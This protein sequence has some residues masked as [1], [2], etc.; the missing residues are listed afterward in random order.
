MDKEIFKNIPGYEGK[1][2]VSNLG[3][4]KSLARPMRGAYHNKEHIL[5]SCID[6]KG[7]ENIQLCNDGKV[8][9]HKIHRLI[10]QAFIPNPENKPCINH[11]DHN[12]SNNIL[13]NLE[14]VTHR[15]NLLHMIKAGRNTPRK[16]KKHILTK[17]TG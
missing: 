8:K 7:Y 12:R 4:V 11:I 17:K 5:K 15:E 2:Q 16:S 9:H 3:R 1:Y 10:A 13:S 6:R 14:W